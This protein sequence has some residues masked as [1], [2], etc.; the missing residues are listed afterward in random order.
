M[1]L[2][3]ASSFVGGVLII[4]ASV[5]ISIAAIAYTVIIINTVLNLAGDSILKR[6]DI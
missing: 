6:E 2:V 3:L 4:Q 1:L 5:V